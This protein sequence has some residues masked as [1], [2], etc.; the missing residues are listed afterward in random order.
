[1]LRNAVWQ[2][3]R[4]PAAAS[5][6]LSTCMLSACVLAGCGKKDAAEAENGATLAAVLASKIPRP[7]VAGY[8]HLS[9]VYRE[10]VAG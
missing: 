10:A 4:S 1:M 9:D 8:V 3:L 2:R 7:N 6:L 5:L